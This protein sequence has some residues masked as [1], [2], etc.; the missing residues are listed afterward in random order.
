VT[1]NVAEYE[2]VLWGLDALIELGRK[3]IRLRA[4]R[5]F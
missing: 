2:A 5:S 4:I 3:E 1:N